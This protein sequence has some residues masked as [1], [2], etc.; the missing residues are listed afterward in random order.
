MINLPNP[1][2]VDFSPQTET[3]HWEDVSDLCD[4]YGLVLDPWQQH[5]LKGALGERDDGQWASSKVGLSIARQSGKSALLEARELGGLL[6][7]G[8]ELIVHSAHMV[9]TAL[10][11]FQRI[12]FYFENYDDLGKKVRQIR[13]ANGEQGIYMKSGQRLFFRARSKQSLRGFSADCLLFDEAQVLTDETWSAVLPTI[14]ARPNP[15]IWLTGTPPTDMHDGEVFHRIRQA[16]FDATDRRLTW[17]EWSADHGDDL[18]DPA[19]WAKANP[20][21]GL[22]PRLE[23]VEGER[24]SMSDTMFQRERLGIWERSDHQGIIPA[25]LWQA[26]R[27]G[28]DEPRA[29]FDDDK[30]VVFAVDMPYDRSKASISISGEA[31]GTGLPMVE[32]VTPNVKSTAELVE[33]IVERFEKW[34]P[35]SLAL[36]ASSPAGTLILPL[37]DRGITV[38]QINTR[39]FISACGLF[40]DAVTSQNLVHNGQPGMQVALE[41][42]TRKWINDV[43]LWQRRN[44][45]VD[46]SPVIAATLA[47]YGWATRTSREPKGRQRTGKV[48]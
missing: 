7:F 30:G 34:G 24:A 6:L 47:H 8:E 10:E 5:V 3:N 25:E 29:E 35:I 27:V 48:W 28:E 16:A 42:A 19:V 46:M 38:T 11:S 22:R 40:H 39:E 18:D 31:L 9:P 26:C 43:W 36:D 45:R 20:G 1:P 13:T 12:R 41:G 44:D 14:S 33:W 32:V 2:T 15:Q 37:E 21:L 17:V 23:A 4:A